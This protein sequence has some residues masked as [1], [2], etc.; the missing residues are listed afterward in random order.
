MLFRE[1]RGHYPFMKAP[2]SNRA[3]EEGSE[4]SAGGVMTGGTLGEKVAPTTEVK[5]T[6]KV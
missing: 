1:K 4:S 3:P 6:D 5:A 2:V